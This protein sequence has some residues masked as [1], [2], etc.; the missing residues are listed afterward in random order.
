MRSRRRSLSALVVILV[1]AGTLLAPRPGTASSPQGLPARPGDLLGLSKE[2]IYKRLGAPTTVE[3]TCDWYYAYPLSP[4]FRK[5]AN[6]P[7]YQMKHFLK[8][9]ITTRVPG[10]SSHGAHPWCEEVR[11]EYNPPTI[12]RAPYTV[13]A[14]LPQR[15]L[16]TDPTA[17]WSWDRSE[18]AGGT[19]SNVLFSGRYPT[20]K[21]KNPEEMRLRTV[22]PSSYFSKK[23]NVE[24]GAYE[25]SWHQTGRAW[26][27]WPVWQFTLYQR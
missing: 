15:Y 12:V 19:L 6:V 9:S 16:D 5:L 25:W 14:M 3:A 21:Y 23:F 17:W 22:I 8:V 18:L 13:A 24:K 20:Q 10:T 7:T 2:E 26:W 27:T 11:Y 1:L 4:P